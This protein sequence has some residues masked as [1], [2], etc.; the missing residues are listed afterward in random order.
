MVKIVPHQWVDS[1]G[2]SSTEIEVLLDGVPQKNCT[3]ADDEAGYVIRYTERHDPNAEEWRTERVEEHVE[4]RKL[5]RVAGI[6]PVLDSL[7]G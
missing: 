5:E 1:L 3:E 4:F 7:E 2:C 6:E